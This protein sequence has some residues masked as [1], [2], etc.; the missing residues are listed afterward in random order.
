MNYLK[1]LEKYAEL[2]VNIGANVQVNQEVI[3]S[4][5]IH[6][7]DLTRLITKN[8]TKLVLKM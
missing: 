7:T 2:A 1:N 8:A 3:L 4:A 6:A 5:P